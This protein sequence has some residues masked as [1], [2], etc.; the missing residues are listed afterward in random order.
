[1]LSKHMDEAKRDAVAALGVVLASEREVRQLALIDD[2]FGRLRVVLW[3]DEAK[4]IDV[5][6]K[7][8][9]AL[10]QAA[11]PF[12]TGDIWM[13]ERGNGA[14]KLVYERAWNDSQTVLPTEPRLRVGE[15]RRNRS[16]WFREIGAT[17]WSLEGGE[18][19][20]PIITFYSF[21][22]GVGRTTALAAFAIHRARAGER[23]AVIDMDLDAPGVGTLLAADKQG[24]T[25][26]WGAIDYLLERVVDELDLRDYY[27][28]CRREAVTRQGEI[29]VVPAGALAPER[30]YLNKLARIDFEPPLGDNARHPL[31][32]LLEHVR[33]ELLPQWI[34]LDAR[35]GLSEP[36]GILLG[37]VA[38][39]HVLFGTSSEQSWQGIRVIL[40]RVG[41]SRA[42]E[43]SVQLECILTHAMV[44]VDTK[45]GTQAKSV[46]AARALEEFRGHYY[47]AD[48]ADPEEDQLWYV[49]DSD[50]SDAPHVPI[51]LSYQPKLA[52]FERIDDVAD[53]LADSAEYKALTERIQQRFL[54]TKE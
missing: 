3:V 36:A 23:V 18:A 49:R 39:L 37:G 28:A 16:A 31:H 2:L 47:A 26:P 38:H 19:G 32:L 46:F 33:K 24:T 48:P 21:K 15:R 50:G 1:M 44:P 7:V 35:A 45:A 14:D 10:A 43:G 52:H 8:D 11:G 9:H 30:E 54:S 13:A 42:R 25:A 4:A 22:G 40:E 51:A 6:A 29:V 5:T 12:W 17:P 41:A 53:A 20:P 27:H 34:L